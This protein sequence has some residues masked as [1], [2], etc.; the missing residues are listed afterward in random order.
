MFIFTSSFAI[1]QI[2]TRNLSIEKFP[3]WVFSIFQCVFIAIILPINVPINVNKDTID[4]Y[5]R[6]PD[7]E[8]A[9]SWWSLKLVG[10]FSLVENTVVQRMTGW[11]SLSL[12]HPGKI[13]SECKNNKFHCYLNV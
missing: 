2:T 7:R 12:Q 4:N 8:Y 13:L 3:L 10:L 5:C 11:F 6:I 9:F 1:H